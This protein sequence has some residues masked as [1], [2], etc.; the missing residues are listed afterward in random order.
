[1]AVVEQVVPVPPARVFAVLKDGWSYSDWVVGTAHIRAVEPDWPRPGASLYHKAGPWPLSI[2]DRSTVVFCD[3]PYQLTIRAGVWPVGEAMVYLRLT[4]VDGGATRVTMTEEFS[5]GPL[6]ALWTRLND[7]VL[8][9][10]NREALRR[11]AE[12]ATNGARGA[13]AGPGPQSR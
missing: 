10:R 6:R 5:A 3:E 2:R 9:W 7:L 8:H 11:L 12:L 13:P 4:P 1:M